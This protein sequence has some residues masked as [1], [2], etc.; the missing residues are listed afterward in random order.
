MTKP[1]WKSER[2]IYRITQEAD[3]ENLVAALCDPKT[4]ES[5]HWVPKPYTLS[6]AYDWIA[7]AKSGWLSKK[8]LLFSALAKDAGD[9]VGSINLHRKDD[10][11]AEIGYWIASAFHGQ[12]LATEMVSFIITFCASHIRVAHLFATTD[13]RNVASQR[14]LRKN[15]FLKV[16]GIDIQTRDGNSRASFV[17]ER[18]MTPGDTK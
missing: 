14:V 3:A 18:A 16:A 12:G 1:T 15:G 2:L 13:T 10:S 7:R 6:D 5:I 17:F 4:S 8:E 9:Y 11:D